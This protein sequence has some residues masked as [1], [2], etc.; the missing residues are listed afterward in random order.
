MKYIKQ[1]DSIRAIAVLC[2]MVSHWVLWEN[3]RLYHLSIQNVIAAFPFGKIGVDVFFVLSGFLITNILLN[4]RVKAEASNFPKKSLL[5]DFYIRRTL[6]IFPLY[7]FVIFALLVLHRFTGTNITHSFRYF[8]TYTSNFYF[9]RINKFDG[10]VSH[11]WSLAVEEQFY[12]IWPFIILFVRQEKL[13]RAIVIF[14][15]I[16]IISQILMRGNPMS[17]LLTFN[18]FDAFGIGGLLSWAIVYKSFYLEELSYRLG[19]FALVAAAVFVVQLTLPNWVIIPERT[20]ISVITVW[21]IAYVYTNTDDMHVVVKFVLD[22]PV[23]VFLGKI[24]YGIYIYH[25]ILPRLT[26]KFLETHINNHLPW[27][28]RSHQVIIE[29]TEYLALTVLVAWLSWKYFEKPILKY[30]DRFTLFGKA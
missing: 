14:I 9:F 28:I 24:S 29:T 12:L 30:K 1:F 20:L 2:V 4:N 19:I 11:L 17:K 6:R 3:M 18:C 22:N 26:W 8:V 5:R 16:G 25:L 27:A 21:L 13:L 10:I 23:L 15:S 7:Y